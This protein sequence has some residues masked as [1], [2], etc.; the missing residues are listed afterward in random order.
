MDWG[1]ALAAAFGMTD[2]VWRR[3][4]NPWSVWTRIP[5]IGLLALAAWSRVWIGAWA[6]VPLAVLLVWTWLNPRVFPAPQS[7]RNWAS[8]GV[9]GER[10]WLA[11]DRHP[12]PEHHRRAVIILSA[13]SLFGLPLL[14]WGLYALE[15]WPTL[16]GLTVVVLF[17]LWFVDR[18]VWLYGD[19]KDQVPEYN[20]WFY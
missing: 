12:I 20:S 1:R 2:E 16:L 8:K 10:V 19:M 9:L 5:L 3:H 14:I 7:T 6:L 11:R 13:F 17:K 15:I 4:A 18:M